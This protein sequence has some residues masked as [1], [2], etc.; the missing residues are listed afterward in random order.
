MPAVTWFA[1]IVLL[2]LAAGILTSAA[3][4]GGRAR[5]R[6]V[7]L[8]QDQGAPLARMREVRVLLT[9]GRI[10][11]LDVEAYIRG[12]V[13]AEAW[14]PSRD[15]RDVAVRAFELQA[16]IAR[17]YLAANR[18]RHAAAGA[19][20]CDT[21][22]CQI[23]RP[24][25]RA[26]AMAD[27]L[28]EGVARTADRMLLF[29]GVPALTLFHASCGGSTSAPETIWGGRTRP[30]LQSVEDEACRRAPQPWRLRLERSALTR[31]LDADPRTRIDGRLDA[32]D[33]LTRDAGDRIVLVGLI[34][35]RSPLV[36]G[37]ELRT[38]L[39]RTFGPRSVR[40]ARFTVTREHDAFVLEGTGFGHGAG[41]C[42]AGALA[43]LRA[44]VLVA[45]VVAHY[46]PGVTIGS[47]GAT[48]S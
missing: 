20:V 46:Y 40:S 18:G 8:P 31:A 5:P 14:V 23:H 42:Q 44:G 12:T 21:T 28:D 17:T 45:D 38:V 43:Q 11:R 29:E 47:V 34:G 26:H 39:V 13:E 22:H 10:E 33:V 37:E 30:Y 27:R 36:R 7:P 6:P 48:G 4:C 35:A 41:L 15:T 3:A 24:P 9:S 32:I 1:R 25:D 19:D 2:G 16:L